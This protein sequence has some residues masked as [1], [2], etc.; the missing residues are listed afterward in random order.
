MSRQQIKASALASVAAFALVTASLA[1]TNEPVRLCGKVISVSG[2]ARYATN[3]SDFKVLRTGA[4]LGTGALVQ[5]GAR[6]SAADIS[7]VGADGGGRCILRIC[8]NSVLNLIG[9]ES[10][11]SGSFRLRDI[12]LGVAQGQVRVSLDGA[13]G[14]DFEIIGGKAPVH[15]S[16]RRD[17][18]GP[19]ETVFVFGLPGTLTVLKGMVKATTSTVA[20]KVIKAGEQL[21]HDSGEVV[22]L[23]PESPE[24][25]P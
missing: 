18:T 16:V 25:K 21:R 4:E 10:K 15:L 7:L 14:Y 5:T 6:D 8:T 13:S 2:H 9:L 11:K 1:Q 23:P 20:E 19:Q 3:R 12:R 17:G 24:L 22:R